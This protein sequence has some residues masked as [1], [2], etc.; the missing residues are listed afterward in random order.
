MPQTQDHQAAKLFMF[1]PE[2]IRPTTVHVR[3]A[4]TTIV[5]KLPSL[6][7]ELSVLEHLRRGGDGTLNVDPPQN[8]DDDYAC[9]LQRVQTALHHLDESLPNGQRARTEAAMRLL[10]RGTAELQA[11]LS[12]RGL[13]L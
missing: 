13:E 10:I 12:A 3:T 2:E 8:P 6:T 4:M 5:G 1:A 11:F 7:E 9:A